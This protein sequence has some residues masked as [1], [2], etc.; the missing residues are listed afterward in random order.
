MSNLST[1]LSSIKS[2]TEAQP[3]N[4]NTSSNTSTNSSTEAPT[5]NTPL[6]SEQTL[7]LILD[8]DVVWLCTYCQ[9][10][11][12]GNDDSETEV[13]KDS[14]VPSKAHTHC[15]EEAQMEYFA[16]GGEDKPS[17]FKHEAVSIDDV[18]KSAI[19]ST[20]TAELFQNG[21]NPRIAMR[22]A[23]A[24]VGAI[25]YL[26]EDIEVFLEALMD[27]LTIIEMDLIGVEEQ[28]IDE[29][30]GKAIIE[31]LHDANYIT[32]TIEVTG[33]GWEREETIEV[34]TRFAELLSARTEAYPPALASVG[35]ERRFD[36]APTQDSPLFKEAV[37]ALESSPY[38]VDAEMLSIARQVVAQT[39]GSDEDSEGYVIAGCEKMDPLEAYVSE[40]KGDR[41][42]RLY[43][44]ACHGPNGQSSDRSRALM[45]LAGVPLDY[46]IIEI[47][48]VLRAEMADMVSTEDSSERS[49]LVRDAVKD[50]VSF[51]I[52]HLGLKEDEAAETQVSKPYS[53]VKAAIILVKLSK[54]QR[55]YLGMAAG[56]DAKCSGPQ[57]GA[58][59]VGDQQIA[60]ACGFSM[61]KVDDAYERTLIEC[62]KAGFTHLKRADIKQA[63]MGIFYG[64]GWGAFINEEDMSP[65][66]WNCI[67]GADCIFG[68][69]ARAKKFHKAVC[70]SFGKKMMAVRGAIKAYGKKIDGRIKHFMPDGFEVAMNYKQ[71]V[72]MLGEHVGY[73]TFLPDVVVRNNAESYKFIKFALNTKEIHYSDFA[74]NGFVNMIQGVDALIARLIIVHLKRLGAKHIICVH[75][76]FRVNMTEMA[77]LDQAI[78]NAYMDLFG[79]T[80]N[81]P[82]KDLPN[83]VDILGLYFE[84]ANRVLRE[85]ADPVMIT[86]FFTSGTRRLMKIGGERLGN[87]IKSLGTTYY[88]SK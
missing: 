42:G 65:V 84:G 80:M 72:N 21:L 32:K 64:Q 30:D 83:G 27:G 81:E 12:I 31:A 77:L 78:M 28:P 11:V 54:G 38:T 34:S 62:A 51:I 57:L 74:R 46:D 41:R 71:K 16:S 39:G 40:F 7:K 2:S 23:A 63:F 19:L 9:E 75:D 85:E 3:M 26:E 88:F 52:R 59:M 4:T 33:G 6:T 20:M 60:Q 15:I 35:V 87:L 86:Q 70:A 48:P 66:L 5:M 55:P 50:P 44:A 67:H 17:P 22:T 37:H 49:D 14:G 61:A 68:D 10:E 8:K 47:L 29:L 53:F 56:K 73:D 45:N 43:Q 76:C 25:E 69:E 1:L 18:N 24:F 13:C 58:L 82:T 36:Y 79:G